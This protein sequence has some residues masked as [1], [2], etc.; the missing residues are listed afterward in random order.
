MSHH[1]EVPVHVVREHD[2]EGLRQ[3]AEGVL[4]RRGKGGVRQARSE[5]GGRCA[6]ARIATKSTKAQLPFRCIV[7]LKGR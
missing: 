1:L 7:G 6:R 5:S 3:V 4:R 2:V